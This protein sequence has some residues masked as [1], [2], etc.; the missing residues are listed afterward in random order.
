M[1]AWKYEI[2]GVLPFFCVGLVGIV[3][4]LD[5]SYWPILVPSIGLIAIAIFCPIKVYLDGGQD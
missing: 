5:K 4:Y 2:F 3:A 1:K